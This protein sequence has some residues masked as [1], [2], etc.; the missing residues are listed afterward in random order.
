[1]VDLVADAGLLYVSDREG[2]T[3]AV[4]D[5]KGYLMARCEVGPGVGGLGLGPAGQVYAAMTVSGSIVAVDVLGEKS[6]VTCPISDSAG[7]SYPLDCLVLG[8]DR[9]LVTDA[10]SK[11]VLVL[12]PLGKVLGSLEGFRFESPFGLARWLDHAV[13]VSDSDLGVVAAFDLGGR[14]VSS[15]GEGHLKTPAFVAARDDGILCI[16]DVGKMTLEVFKL[17]APAE[18]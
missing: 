15:F 5:A 16:A 2:G 3:I 11:Q 9:V 10:A 4:L 12:S 8:P 14:F 7:A 6:L 17:D 13:L 18:K 1:L